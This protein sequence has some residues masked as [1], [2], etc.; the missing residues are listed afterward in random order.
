M[1]S[2]RAHRDGWR[3]HVNRL[4]ERPLWRK[5]DVARSKHSIWVLQQIHKLM[6]EKEQLVLQS[7]L[8]Q[9]LHL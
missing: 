8:I 2:A 3:L 6:Y 4:S 9:R 7:Q 5:L 1:Q